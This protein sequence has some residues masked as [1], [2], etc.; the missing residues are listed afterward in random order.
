MFQVLDGTILNSARRMLSSRRTRDVTRTKTDPSLADSPLDDEPMQFRE[1]GTT[2]VYPLPSPYSGDRTMGS[3]P[4]S[5][6]QLQ[7]PHQFVSRNHALLRY[8]NQRWSIVDAGS[9]NGLWIDG[10]RSS[11][12]ELASG[13]EVGLGRV[14]LIVESP[15]TVMQRD[16]LA[17]LLGWA[18]DRQVVIDR[19][20]RQ[21]RGYVANEMPLWLT[22]DDDLVAIA[23][24]IHRTFIGECPFVV[25]RL[26]DTT[27]R[28]GPARAAARG[29]TLCLRS[30]KPIRDLP[31]VRALALDH[32][33]TTRLVICAR[34]AAHVLPIEIPALATRTDEIPRIIDAYA[35]DAIAKLGAHTAS[36]TNVDCNSIAS[37][38]IETLADIEESV[39][40]MIA[41]REF[42][43]VTGAAPHLGVTHSSL[44]RWLARRTTRSR[45][46][47]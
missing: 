7:D 12:A 34:S 1:W 31:L 8:V 10:H 14:R 18:P 42:G 21:L 25:A 11:A 22:G 2:K 32:Q 47:S 9:K 3:S 35:Q 16:L 33:S 24:L 19:A 27:S 15:R 46:R 36:Y 5:W 23:R 45:N 39:L 30:E 37:W 17:R 13:I 29:G 26:D 38:N 20:L 28:L 4:D 6:L 40:R 43:G 44:S 41:I